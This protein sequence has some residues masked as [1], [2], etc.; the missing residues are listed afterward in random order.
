MMRQ[1][2]FKTSTIL[3]NVILNCKGSH[4]GSGF[5]LCRYNPVSILF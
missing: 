5:G 1:S 2:D 3:V 4:T